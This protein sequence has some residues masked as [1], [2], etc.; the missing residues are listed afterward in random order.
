LRADTHH[1]E[2]GTSAESGHI[3]TILADFDGTACA[4]DVASAVCEAFAADG[5]QALDEAVAR[6]E[7]T[8]R[9]AIDAQASMLRG[10][11]EEMLAFVL[12]RFAVDPTFVDLSAWTRDTRLDLAIVSDGFGFYIAPMLAAAGLDRVPVLANRLTGTPGALRL[13]H[14]FAHPECIGCGTCKMRA[15][16]EARSRRGGVAFVG[17]GESDRFGALFADLVFAKDRLADLCD[18]AGIDYSQWRDF[19]QVRDA[20]AARDLAVT[21]P[22]VADVP[23]R[24]P[25]W[26]VADH[27]GVA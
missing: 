22:R 21:P 6:G 23:V 10:T 12:D 26:T 9:A 5:W 18:A 8:L 15:V 7:L 25:G 19:H 2:C 3:G 27:E 14:P 1:Q 11:R 13:E 20:V 16:L 24:C 4:V 17:E